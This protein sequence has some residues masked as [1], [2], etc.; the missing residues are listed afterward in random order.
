MD[1]DFIKGLVV[2]LVVGSMIVLLIKMKRNG[3][4]F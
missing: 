2:G 1:P 3:K 4:G